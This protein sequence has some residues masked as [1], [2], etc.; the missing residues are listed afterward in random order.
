M[1]TPNRDPGKIITFYSYK[2]GTG[3]SMTLANVAWVLANNGKRVLAIDWDLEAPGLHRYLHPFLEDSEL[4]ETQGLIDYFVDVT[5][6]ARLAQAQSVLEMTLPAN[7]PAPPWWQAWTSLLSY[8]RSIDFP[9]P[10]D[11]T[12]DL[13]PAGR[14]GPGYAE[15]VGT[16]EWR[17]FYEKLG[18]GVLLEALKVQ[19]RKAYDYVLV[20]SRTGIS[21]TAGICTVQMPDDLVVCFTLNKQS[22]RGAAAAADSAWT[23]RMKPDGVPG[24]RV[25]PVATRLDN[26]EKERLNA[27]LT[28]AKATFQRYI[29]HLRREDRIRYWEETQIMYQPFFAYDEIL[30]PFIER[31]R[32]SGSMLGSIEALT[33]RISDG[34]VRTLGTMSEVERAKGLAAYI[35]QRVAPEPWRH[36]SVYMSYPYSAK[37]HATRIRN[38]LESLGVHLFS[39]MHILLGTDWQKA[40]D[41]GLDASVALLFITELNRPISD[42]QR[43]EL[44]RATLR[45]LPIVPVVVEGEGGLSHLDP[46]LV[47]NQGA[48]LRDPTDDEGVKR[49]AEGLKLL[50]ARANPGVTLI[51]VDDP[52]KGRWGGRPMANGRSLTASVEEIG[53]AWCMIVLD[54]SPVSGSPPVEGEVIFHI[55]PS[56]SDPVRRI[57]AQDGKAVLRMRGWGAFTVGAEVDGGRT[58]LELDLAQDP[59]L[60]ADFRA[61]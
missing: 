11:G 54:V 42:A 58:M 3:R 10:G 25:W 15:R 19:L 57:P 37:Q 9:F 22:V 34:Q 56:F 14:Q 55:H 1:T 61:R 53:S 43:R 5:V 26:A 32:G 36:A 6:A 13:V 39:D 50:N 44:D 60:P 49:L 20:D 31:S 48:D 27:G 40:L 35:P 2:G 46:L 24:L 47:R 17:S 29:T 23:Q 12:I 52:E 18:G 45:G 59:S 8:T 30:A 16:F 21:D 51:D 28:D 33:A 38:S 7:E 41:E 4:S